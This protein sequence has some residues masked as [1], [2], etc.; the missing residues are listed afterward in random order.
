MR[1]KSM[2]EHMSTPT[3]LRNSFPS[4]SINIKDHYSM[5][6]TRCLILPN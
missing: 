2:N 4:T 6:Y 3:S 1:V 5:F